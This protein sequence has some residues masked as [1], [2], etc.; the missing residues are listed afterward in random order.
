MLVNVNSL[1]VAFCN[2]AGFVLQGVSI[3]MANFSEVL[4]LGLKISDTIL[5]NNH[6]RISAKYFFFSSS[7]LESK[8]DLTSS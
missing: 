2:N 8:R 3:K 5:K 4:G 1:V 7:N 6:H